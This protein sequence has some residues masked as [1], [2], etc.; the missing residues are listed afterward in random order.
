MSVTPK[1]EAAR[2]RVLAAV[3]ELTEATGYAPNYREIAQHA[4]LGGLRGTASV[5]AY[6]LR[7]LRAA[8]LVRFDPDVSRSIVLTTGP[9][10]HCHGTGSAA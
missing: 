7:V 9:C 1:G 8:G 6:H 10:A 3:R 2:A 4:G 5:T